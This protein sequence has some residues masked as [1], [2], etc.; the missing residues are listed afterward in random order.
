[1]LLTRLEEKRLIDPPPLL[2][3]NCQYLTIA[4][5][6]S[7]GCANAADQDDPSDID[8]VGFWIPPKECVFPHLRGEIPGFSTPGPTFLKPWESKAHDPDACG[9]R[10]QDY[11]IKI[12][13]IVPMFKLLMQCNPNL[14]DA[15]FTK[16]EEVLHTTEVGD[17]VRE[18]RKLFL[19]KGCFP[20]FVSYAS[21]QLHKM[22]A[23]NPKKGSKRADL[24]ERFGFD[25]KFG[26][27]LVRN[28]LQ[29]EQILLE[30]DM[31]LHRHS[32][33]LKAI[34][35][36][37]IC[38]EEIQKWALDKKRQLGQAYANSKLPE[39]PDEKAVKHLLESCLERHYGTLR[40]M[41]Y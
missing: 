28:L 31:D 6:H 17:M 37:D 15:I 40:G 2:V 23:K 18:N 3:D 35:R 26:M 34:R 14:I 5:S 33:H 24:R 16:Q 13:N 1:M 25:V 10:G 32:E 4:G 19:H 8:C 21:E 22:S 36:G 38:E 11:D 27:H 41:I 20:R 30:G 9:G 7:Y 12:F 39:G 29:V